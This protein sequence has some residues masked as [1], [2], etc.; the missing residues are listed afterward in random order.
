MIAPERLPHPSERFFEQRK[1]LVELALGLQQHAEVADESQRVWVIVAERFPISSERLLE[2]RP[3][4]FELA[5]G[6]QI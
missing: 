6:F 2:Q 4:L 1:G 5:L 3:G